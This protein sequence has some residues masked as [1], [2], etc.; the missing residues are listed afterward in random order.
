MAELE[1]PGWDLT[2]MPDDPNVLSQ[3]WLEHYVNGDPLAPEQIQSLVDRAL[4]HR[5]LLSE[6]LCTHNP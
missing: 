1:M 2:Q 3:T 4:M 5:E 6:V